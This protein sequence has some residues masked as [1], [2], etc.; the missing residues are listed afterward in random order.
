M[1]EKT[2]VLPASVDVDS[3]ETQEWL[4]A[5][6]SLIEHHGH[7]R[8]KHILGR[9]LE[10]L[11]E[12]GY[13]QLLTTPFRN[14]LSTDT[15]K[16]FNP[17]AKKASNIT[18]WNAIAMVLQAGAFA[19]EL[20]GHLATYASS[21]QLYDMGFDHFFKG[22]D[23][24]GG[25][26]VYFQG[27][28]SPGIYA[29]AHCEGRLPIE[30]LK[31]FRQEA[32]AP[33]LSS[34]PHPWLMPDFWQFPTVSMGLGAM[35]AIYQA[36]FL[37]Y[38]EHRGLAQTNQRKVWLFCGDGEMDEPESQGALTVAGRESLSNLILVLNCNLQ[39]LDGPVR[40]NAKIVQEME[41]LFRGAGWRVIKAIWGQQWEQLLA[42]DTDGRLQAVLDNVVDGSMQ[43]F[44]LLSGSGMR[45]WLIEQDVELTSLLSTMTDEQLEQ[46]NRGGHDDHV[47]YT[48]FE[49]ATKT[50]H[51]PT[52]ILIN[53][54][55]GYGLGPSA[56][57]TNGTHQ[58][59]KLSDADRVNIAKHLELEL[60]EEQAIAAELI[61]INNHPDVLEHT[62]ATRQAL[63]G[64]VP[65]RTSS[66]PLT[67]PSLSSLSSMLDGSGER[68]I[69]TT[70]GFVRL[71]SLLL[72]D[73]IIKDRIVP[74][75]PDESRTFGMEGLFRQIGI[76]ASQ[77]QQYTPID[78][79][80]VMYYRES[81]DGQYLQEGISEA[82]A[83]CSWLSAATAYSHSQLAMIPFYI[84][85][86]MFGFQ[87]IGDFAW[88]AG[89]MRAR[90]FLLGATAGRTTLAG[91]GLQHQ[92]GHSHLLANTIP[93]C[94]SYDPAF[95]YEVAV[96]IQH[97]LKQMIQEQQDVFYYITL[98]ND[99]QRQPAM[100]KGAEKGIINGMHCI[101][102]CK[103]P[104]AQHVRL[105]GSGAIVSEVQQAS[106]ILNKT[107]DISTQIWSVTSY[108]LLARQASDLARKHRIN[109]NSKPILSHV[110][111]CLEG[112]DVTVAAS[113]Y[114]AVCAQQIQPYLTCPFYA[115]GTDGFGR[116]DT[117]KA[118]RQHFEVDANHIAYTA[119]FGLY[120][121]GKVP[122]DTLKIA[123]KK[124][125][126][127]GK[128][129]NPM[130]V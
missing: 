106:E 51:Q 12:K 71:L 46:L 8:A 84:Y 80:Q 67:A 127:D 70:M 119:I 89:D 33:G 55:K 64:F 26:C 68:Q 27:H 10:K 115:L 107:F 76:Y 65:Q 20:G 19:S 60:T 111:Q 103:K 16:V 66:D 92:D 120:K 123:K 116:S 128:K 99:N 39:R 14:T 45:Q 96:I 118:L 3:I 79:K 21:A 124:L 82:G 74:I 50:K 117:R 62:M 24:Q 72:K 42:R 75:A 95:V 38:L 56:H 31:R 49:E 59:K 122:L 30:L 5:L 52:V 29:R 37:R 86:S 58:Q 109:P 77:G 83:F 43:H 54:I 36:R 34:Y 101:E 61:D 78:R 18:R 87:R 48:A 9:M 2:S 32:Q 25:D 93:N 7:A 98:M 11:D 104:K 102:P 100:P 47:I 23:I 53:T 40:G 130:D 57:G 44:A 6:S 22:P 121:A 114:M 4:D 110:E 113:D 105:L 129:P 13:Q 41:S 94:L 90:G 17:L 28:A 1:Q 85:Y 88:A 69:S 81:Q 73:P 35:Q 112:D 125:G 108:P 97:G 126:I 15:S 91:E 63:G